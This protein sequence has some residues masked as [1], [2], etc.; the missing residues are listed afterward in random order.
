MT[1]STEAAKRIELYLTNDDLL[2][3][4][5][6]L[7][8]EREQELNREYLDEDRCTE[9]LYFLDTDETV[10]LR[11]L[12]DSI[13]D[14]ICADAY[15]DSGTL[16]ETLATK[17]VNYYNESIG[18]WLDVDDTPYKMMYQSIDYQREWGGRYTICVSMLESGLLSM[19]T[20]LLT[21][22][23][24]EYLARAKEMFRSRSG[25]ISYVDTD[26]TNWDISDVQNWK[27]GQC[28]FI[29]QCAIELIGGADYSE[30]LDELH[31]FGLYEDIDVQGVDLEFLA[32]QK[33]GTKYFSLS[34]LILDNYDVTKEYLAELLVGKVS[35]TSMLSLVSRTDTF[36][37]DRLA[38]MLSMLPNSV[39]THLGAELPPV[40]LTSCIKKLS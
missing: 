2:S 32:A 6:H 37:K 25:F 19:H 33:V 20:E 18:D 35:G 34:E 8:Q 12:P 24:T 38:D 16:A 5:V 1:H 3:A 7:S 9:T 39:K 40:E 11:A 29:V 14:S 10:N 31:S 26:V 17:V 13:K 23:L 27:Y 15:T 36:S 30:L 4:P 28:W 21:S 22:Q